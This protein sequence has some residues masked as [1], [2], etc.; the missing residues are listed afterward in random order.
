MRLDSKL[1]G[2][3]ERWTHRTQQAIIPILARQPTTGTA[4]PRHPKASNN[5]LNTYSGAALDIPLTIN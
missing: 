1:P 4:R 3:M 5:S 2:R